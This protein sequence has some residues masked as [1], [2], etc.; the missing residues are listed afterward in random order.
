MVSRNA[1]QVLLVSNRRRRREEKQQFSNFIFMCLICS[2]NLD[3]FLATHLKNSLVIS[4]HYL[5]KI[6]RTHCITLSSSLA[7]FTRTYIPCKKK[8]NEN[9][10]TPNSDKLLNYD[11]IIISTTK[12]EANSEILIK[13]EKKKSKFSLRHDKNSSKKFDGFCSLI[14]IPQYWNLQ[15]FGCLFLILFYLAF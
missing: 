4:E 6:K 5:H 3:M 10:R 13:K 1:N 9:K 8:G 14:T 15:H 11:N 2:E 12:T 7:D